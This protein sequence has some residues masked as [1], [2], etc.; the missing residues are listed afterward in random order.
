MSTS[1]IQNPERKAVRLNPTLTESVLRAC[2]RCEWRHSAEDGTA[3][4]GLLYTAP[5]LGAGWPGDVMLRT[6]VLL[7]DGG[8]PCGRV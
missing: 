6:R 3:T 5:T 7:R 1:S 4:A 2:P 8:L